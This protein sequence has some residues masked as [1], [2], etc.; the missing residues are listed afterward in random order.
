MCLTAA[1]SSSLVLRSRFSRSREKRRHGTCW[2]RRW[3]LDGRSEFT[4]CESGACGFASCE[5]RCFFREVERFF[6]VRT[7]EKREE[8]FTHG[9]EAG[10]LVHII[11]Q[12]RLR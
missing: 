9:N 2:R 3:R 1:S 6:P 12:K 10:P 11:S 5:L 7:N 4:E 8:H